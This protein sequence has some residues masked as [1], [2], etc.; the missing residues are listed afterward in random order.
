[1]GEGEVVARSMRVDSSHPHFRFDRSAR[2]S[3]WRPSSASACDDS[4]DPVPTPGLI[5]LESRRGLLLVSPSFHRP[6]R[7]E[8][9]FAP[10]AARYRR[11]SAFR[12]RDRWEAT[13]WSLR[14]VAVEAAG[15]GHRV[16]LETFEG[17]ARVAVLATHAEARRLAGMIAG[18]LGIH[19]P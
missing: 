18:A 16:L 5:V 19:A 1:M 8:W 17:D 4:G 10:D 13:P 15:A 6:S 2:R 12:P 11:F 3:A 7:V 14:G 9:S